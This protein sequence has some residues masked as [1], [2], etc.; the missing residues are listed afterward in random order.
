MHQDKASSDALGKAGEFTGG[1]GTAGEQLD[2]VRTTL[3][4]RVEHV[5]CE[6]WAQRRDAGLCA[7]QRDVGAG[8]VK[9]AAFGDW[10]GG[11]VCR[12]RE[13]VLDGERLAQQQSAVAAARG[14]QVGDQGDEAAHGI[15]AVGMGGGSGPERARLLVLA[16]EG[17][18][19]LV[20]EDQVEEHH[21]AGAGQLRGGQ[22]VEARVAAR[23]RHEERSVGGVLIGGQLEGVLG[24]LAAGQRLAA[25]LAGE[26]GTGSEARHSGQPRGQLH[27]GQAVLAEDEAA[28]AAVVPPQEEREGGIAGE[29]LRSEVVRQPAL[30]VLRVVRRQSQRVVARLLQL[31][32]R[33]TVAWRIAQHKVGEPAARQRRRLLE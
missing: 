20:G 25:R 7:H 32:H 11:E 26:M 12:Q 33:E 1:V 19:D 16:E 30:V 31:P 17:Q 28:H 9:V 21:L 13:G 15:G 27:R 23:V 22:G 24:L 2:Q 3:A 10:H 6:E 8:N 4:L 18:V 29:A 5:L 14:G